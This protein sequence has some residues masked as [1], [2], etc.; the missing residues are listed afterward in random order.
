MLDHVIEHALPKFQGE[1]LVSKE[2]WLAR[3]YRIELPREWGKLTG[4]VAWAR[5]K[6]EMDIQRLADG[7]GP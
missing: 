1:D 4:A 6:V 5:I 3:L 2:R 7:D